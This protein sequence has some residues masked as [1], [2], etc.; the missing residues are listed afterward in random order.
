M[1]K[2]DRDR[3]VLAAARVAKLREQLAEAESELDS[4]LNPET[5]SSSLVRL[6]LEFLDSNQ[7]YT[8]SAREIVGHLG[9][10]TTALPTIRATLHRLA[11]QGRIRTLG[12]GHFADLNYSEP[13]DDPFTFDETPEDDASGDEEE[14]S[15]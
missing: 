3:L 5:E 4:I 6:I 7:G 12:G 2:R 14:A 10:E 1:N 15:A 8:W 11:N 9:R 13:G